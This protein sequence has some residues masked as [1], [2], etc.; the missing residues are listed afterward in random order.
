MRPDWQVELYKPNMVQ[1]ARGRGNSLAM[2][3]IDDPHSLDLMVIQRVGTEASVRFLRWAQEHG[4]AV[5]VDADDAMWCIDR[6]NTAWASWNER[7]PERLHWKWADEAAKHADLVTVTTEALAKRYGAH[8][9]CEVHPNRVFASTLDVPNIRDQFDPTPTLGWSGFV[10]THPHDLQVVG[11]A[12]RDA[13]AATGALVRVV[14][15]PTGAEAAW[16]LPEGTVQGLG[17]YPLGPT[18]FSGLTAIDVGA[19]PLDRSTFNS[20]KSSLKALELS[21]AGAAVVATPTPAN[22]AL[23]R[24]LPI[25]L[26]E[27][28]RQWVEHLTRLLSDGDERRERGEQAREIVRAEWTIESAGEAWAQAWGR[29]VSRRQR[30]VA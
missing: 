12:V 28:E 21:A 23:A 24:Q 18:Y 25:L 13:V 16:G 20:N 14:A 22:R 6:D 30:M 3:G 8:G 10:G 4:I 15:D 27:S 7:T 26:A 19:V 9:R 5:V 2:R 1:L 11:T 17:P 29:A